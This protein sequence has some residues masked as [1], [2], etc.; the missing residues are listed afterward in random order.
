MSFINRYNIDLLMT[1]QEKIKRNLEIINNSV[2]VRTCNTY[3]FGVA[4]IDTCCCVC[5]VPLN[6]VPLVGIRCGGAFYCDECHNVECEVER[7]MEIRK[8]IKVR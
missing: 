7:K 5:A 1:E 8:I 6:D 3:A 2:F 4:D